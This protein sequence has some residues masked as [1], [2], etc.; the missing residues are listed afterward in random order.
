MAQFVAAANRA[1]RGD[2]GTQ[3][4][5]SVRRERFWDSRGNHS[6]RPLVRSGRKLSER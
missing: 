1:S 2:P 5:V 6:P 3:N 4:G